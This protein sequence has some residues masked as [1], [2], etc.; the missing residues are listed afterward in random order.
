MELWKS[1]RSTILNLN[2]IPLE[3]DKF[4]HIYNRANGNEKIF[5]NDG[6]YK[7]FLQKYLKYI[8]P[9]ADTFCYCLMPNHFHFLIK[10]KSQKE[11]TELKDSLK[12]E[13]QEKFCSKQ[14]SNLFSSYTQSFNKQQNRLGGL[15]IKNFKRKEIKSDSYLYKLVNYIHY[16]PVEAGMVK[17]LKDWK[18]SSFLTLLSIKPTLLKRQQVLELYGGVENFL[19]TH[20]KPSEL[21][22]W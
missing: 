14:F 16:N 21:D 11:L 13:N 1:F 6:N 19:F 3:P 5:L 12:Y 15:L 10:I 9:I 22:E 20:S 18:Y 2:M 7:F 17:D 8:E 4:Y